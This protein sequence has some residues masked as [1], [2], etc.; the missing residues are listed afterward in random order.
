[1]AIFCPFSQVQSGQL[2]CFHCWVNLKRMPPF[3]R[4]MMSSLMTSIVH[5]LA[6]SSYLEVGFNFRARVPHFLWQESGAQVLASHN[7]L[8]SQKLG[9]VY[10]WLRTRFE[11][12]CSTWVLK[13]GQE[14]PILALSFPNNVKSGL[15]SAS[16]LG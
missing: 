8:L 7:S 14:S 6:W 13:C 12:S 1:M 4:P 15:E 2:Q 5:F 9:F 3:K 10:C 16:L 11:G